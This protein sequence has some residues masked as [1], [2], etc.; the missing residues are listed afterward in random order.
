ME[1][2]LQLQSGSA[3]AHWALIVDRYHAQ[4]TSRVFAQHLGCSFDSSWKLV[5]C[6]RQG[7]SFVEIANA[8]FKVEYSIIEVIRINSNVT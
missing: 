5:N 3:V 4:N 8:E 6:L 1:F 2:I 7:R